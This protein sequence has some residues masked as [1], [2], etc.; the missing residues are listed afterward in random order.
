MPFD[1]LFLLLVIVSV[2][3]SDALLIHNKNA[4][5][6]HLFS[7]ASAG[8]SISSADGSN[9]G[10]SN[11]ILGVP[12]QE[13]SSFD[14]AVLN[15][16]ACKRF[17]RFDGAES[18][19]RTQLGVPIRSIRG[20]TSLALSQS[21]PTHTNGFQH[22]AVQSCARPFSPTKARPLSL[23][24]GTERGSHS[25]FRLHGH[26]SGRSTNLSHLGSLSSLL[27]CGPQKDRSE[28]FIT[29]TTQAKGRVPHALLHCSILVGISVAAVPGGAAVVLC[30]NRGRV[31]E[32]VYESVLPVAFP[33]QCR[34]V[35]FQTNGNGC[36]HLH[37]GLHVSGSGDDS[38]GRD[39]RQGHSK[40]DWSSEPVRDS[41]HCEHGST[42]QRQ[43][44]Q[45]QKKKS[46]TSRYPVEEVVFGDS[47]GSPINSLA[48][49]SANAN[50]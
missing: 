21:R 26:L 30:S 22:A 50:E 12:Q 10:A 46:M 15:R 41:S 36:H 37:L 47:F 28:Y 23:R 38:Y 16:Y 18:G 34:N 43:Q 4:R 29:T 5:R 44:Q 1:C 14:T 49:A 8:G 31:R 42:G 17:R 33:G 2:S 24:F 32:P 9:D 11:N 6:S 20:P 3:V 7:S 13:H 40:G 19:G 39:Q 48:S 45:Q 25:R 35:V 27:G